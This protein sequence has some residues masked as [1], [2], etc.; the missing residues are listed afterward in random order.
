MTTRTRIGVDA[1]NE[2]E[3]EELE[4][5]ERDEEGKRSTH[6]EV[7]ARVTRRRHAGV[8]PPVEKGVDG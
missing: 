3:D 5:D 1:P 7:P 8:T 6:D 2:E 4:G